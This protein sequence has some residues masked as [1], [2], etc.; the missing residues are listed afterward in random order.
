[1]LVPIA[2]SPIT[3]VA[4]SLAARTYFAVTL[5]A[6][7]PF[8][9]LLPSLLAVNRIPSSP[10]TSSPLPPGGVVSSPTRP[11]LLP[12]FALATLISLAAT[13]LAH[14][15]ISPYPPLSASLL[16]S[17]IGGS[18]NF[19]QTANMLA[20]PSANIADYAT[21]DIAG[22]GCYLAGLEVIAGGKRPLP[23][24]ETTKGD[25]SKSEALKAVA[26]TAVVVAASKVVAMPFRGLLG[27]IVEVLTLLYLPLALFRSSSSTSLSAV[28]DTTNAAFYAS[29]GLAAGGVTQT[30]MKHVGLVLSLHLAL[31]GVAFKIL[32]KKDILV[33]SNAAV[34]GAGTSVAFAR[35]IGEDEGEAGKVATLGYVVGG[36]VARAWLAAIK[37]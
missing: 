1:M 12:Y 2:T 34:G 24:P 14:I 15:L 30:A 17:Y 27:C 11:K 28:A 22:M 16:S 10:S 21:A 9:I 37:T 3:I 36:A 26:S 35:R 20:I 8:S 31:T 7:V 29:V 32:R 19:A 25:F 23:H 18:I 33:A 6:S 13:H 5:P 4:S